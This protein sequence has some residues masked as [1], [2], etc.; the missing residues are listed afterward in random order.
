MVN[1]TIQRRRLGLAL[2]RAREGA[3]K[4][5]DEAAA[6]IDAA[7]SK[8]SRVELGQSGIKLTDLNLLL[9]LY[10]VR[11]DDAEP[12]RDLARAGRQRGR[13][14]TYRNAVPDWFR[15]YLDLEGD[16]SEIRWYQPEV[17]PGVLQVEP[18]IRAMNAIAHPRPPTDEVDRQVAVR[19]ERQSI[20]RQ[21]NGPDLSFILSESALRRSIGDATTMR[22]QLLHLAEVSEQPNVTLQVFPFNAQTYETASFS[23][24]ILLFPS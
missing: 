2:K 20:L 8:I 15:Q 19:L 1:P 10:G 23:F 18:Y 16:A 5:Q 21:D 6:V 11:D 13:W 3:G 24:I 4:T 7:A 14:S 12:L 22:D 9:D 17:I